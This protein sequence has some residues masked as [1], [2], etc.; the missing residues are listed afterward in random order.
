MRCQDEWNKGG[1]RVNQR[2]ISK[3]V[4]PRATGLRPAGTLRG[5]KVAQVGRGIL[6]TYSHHLGSKASAKPAATQE[7]MTLQ[8][9]R[10]GCPGRSWNTEVSRGDVRWDLRGAWRHIP[11]SLSGPRAK[12]IQGRLP[13]RSSQTSEYIIISVGGC[14]SCFFFAV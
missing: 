5:Q 3:L 7:A 13:S 9:C 6:S 4:K 8:M 14:I 12:G 10:A 1:R 11:V 2:G